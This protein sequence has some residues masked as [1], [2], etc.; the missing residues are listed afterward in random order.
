MIKLAK[1]TITE[2]DISD[3]VEWLGTNPR[4]TKGQE[5][6]KF[7]EQWSKWLGVKHSVYVNSGSSANLVIM[8]AL[9]LSGQMKNNKVVVPAVSWSTTVAPV[10]QFGMD[11]ILCEASR[12]NLGIDTDHFRRICQEQNPAAIILVHVL[13]LPC[14]MKEI[15]SICEE[16]EVILIEDTCE[17]VGSLY[18]E[19]KLG[20]FGLANSFSFYYGHHLS[21]IEGGM[22][23]T[24][25]TD[26]YNILKSIRSH[27]WDRDLDV[28]TQRKLRKENNIDEFRA[29]Y[30]FYYPGFNLRA[31]DLQ[32]F[33]GQNQLLKLDAMVEQRRNNFLL[34][35]EKLE[36]DFWRINLPDNVMVSNMAYPIITPKIDKVVSAL[37]KNNIE[38]RPLICGSIG[39]QPFWIQRYGETKFPMSS[40]VHEY[41]LYV[42]NNHELTSDEIEFMCDVI[43][44]AIKK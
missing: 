14:D 15:N 9:K 34:F 28:S 24:D 44:G 21:T 32:A 36:N 13:G 4:L 3:L 10:I 12:D 39:E 6:L 40:M 25:D 26:F 1:D 35:E 29:L 23:S 37:N 31:T 5:T 38:T 7:E 43:N 2:K 27:G 42:P 33:I 16:Y 17:S 20:T 8:Y 22:V 18:G 11:P 41:G 19:K 30:S